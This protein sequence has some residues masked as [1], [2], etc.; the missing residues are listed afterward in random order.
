V[1]SDIIIEKT[2]DFLYDNAK[3]KKLKPVSLEEL[4]K[5]QVT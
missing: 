2:L 1:E 3:I 5:E 4:V